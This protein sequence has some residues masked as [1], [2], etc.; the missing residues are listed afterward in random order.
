EKNAKPLRGFT[1]LAMDRMSTYRWPGNVR[2]LENVVERAVVLTRG[3]ILDEED[4]PQDLFGARGDGRSISVAI[5]T[6]LEEV[7]RRL[8]FET[9]RYTKD[10]K[11]LAAQLLGIATRTI[12]RR[13]EA[14]RDDEG[15]GA[16]DEGDGAA[17]PS[18]P[19]P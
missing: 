13:L 10:D 19:L 5:G 18:P 14:A 8:I 17:A 1:A 6:P 2:E 4:L 7:E 12:Y 9:L 16:A 3:Q 11:R 15:D